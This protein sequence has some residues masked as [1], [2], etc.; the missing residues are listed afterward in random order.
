[1]EPQ[2]DLLPS[3]L[4]DTFYIRVKKALDVTGGLVGSVPVTCEIKRI[5]KVNGGKIPDKIKELI[6]L[7][8]N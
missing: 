8:I 7:Y 5:E 4:I 1:M 2:K 6:K 3:H